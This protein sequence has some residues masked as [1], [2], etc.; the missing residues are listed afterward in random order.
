MNMNKTKLNLLLDEL[1]KTSMSAQKENDLCVTKAL[2]HK[3][4][5]SQQ[6][7]ENSEL[8]IEYVDVLKNAIIEGFKK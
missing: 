7:Y 3:L 6:H 8:L 4:Q 2:N 5:E 1:I